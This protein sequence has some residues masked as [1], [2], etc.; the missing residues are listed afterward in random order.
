MSDT[1]MVYHICEWI[2]ACFMC[3]TCLTH[4]WFI[5]FV[6][7][8]ERCSTCSHL[9]GLSPL[10]NHSLSNFEWSF[11]Y[12]TLKWLITCLAPNSLSPL[13]ENPCI[14]EVL[15]FHN[16]LSNGKIC[17]AF[18]VQNM[19]NMLDTWMAYIIFDTWMAYGL[20]EWTRAVLKVLDFHNSL[21]E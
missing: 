5:T 17:K 13:W 19:P 18:Q 20:G 12:L 1:W 8:F 14:F 4:V 11:T 2:H 7:S 16:P 21:S 3:L 6:N 15:D 10:W 9:H